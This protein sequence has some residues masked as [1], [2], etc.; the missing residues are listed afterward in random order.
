VPLRSSSLRDP[1]ILLRQFE[2]R[3]FSCA[4]FTQEVTIRALPQTLTERL[5]G[6]LSERPGW[7][8]AAL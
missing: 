5:R 7:S 8:A 2:A 4:L 3:I 1:E 6:D